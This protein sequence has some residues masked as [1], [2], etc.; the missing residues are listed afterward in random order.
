M[1]NPRK[2]NLQ[3][4]IVF[5][6]FRCTRFESTSF[7][8]ITFRRC[9]AGKKGYLCQHN[10]QSSNECFERGVEIG[11][12]KHRVKEENLN[13]WGLRNWPLFPAGCL[14]MNGIVLF[15]TNQTRL[16]CGIIPGIEC[17]CIQ[18]CVKANKYKIEHHLDPSEPTRN[19]IKSCF[20]QLAKHRSKPMW[21]CLPSN[22]VSSLF[23][24]Q[25]FRLAG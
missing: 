22:V 1:N 25:T 12:L 18:S 23:Q 19:S 13:F 24:K 15:N 4:A 11:I 7:F 16:D 6:S 20:D 21:H 17:L 3:Y 5:H 9:N 14:Y 2:Y 10:V 8:S